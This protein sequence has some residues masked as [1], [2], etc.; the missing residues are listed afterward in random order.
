[1]DLPYSIKNF[2]IQECFLTESF[3]ASL[4]WSDL[5]AGLPQ[6]VGSTDADI[7]RIYNTQLFEIRPRIAI[8]SSPFKAFGF[9]DHEARFARSSRAL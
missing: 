5:R 1:M 3:C 9:L 6:S 2:P 7:P 4:S 8:S